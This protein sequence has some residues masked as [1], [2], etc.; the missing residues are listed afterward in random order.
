MAEWEWWGYGGYGSLLQSQVNQAASLVHGRVD[1]R[2]VGQVGRPDGGCR[3][4]HGVCKLCGGCM[5]MCMRMRMVLRSN[6]TWACRCT[7]VDVCT[8]HI[9]QCG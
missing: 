5:G 8:Y 1:H 4:H 6:I 7:T 9:I 3:V 2:H